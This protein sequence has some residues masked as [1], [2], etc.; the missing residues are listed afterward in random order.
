MQDKID[1]LKFKDKILA[2]IIT[3]TLKEIKPKNTVYED[4]LSSII[5]QQ[6]SAKV[7]HQIEIRFRKLFKNNFP[8]YDAL[9]KTHDEKLKSIGLSKQK[10]AYLKNTALFFKE[11]N[12]HN[13]DFLKLKDEEIIKLLTQIKGVGIWTSQM[14]LIFTLGREDIFSIKDIGLVNGIIKLYKLEK[15]YPKSNTKYSLSSKDF[16]KKILK[17]TEKWKPYRS[18]ASRYIW[19]YKDGDFDWEEAKKI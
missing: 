1:Y 10:I 5:G 9:L 7:A 14:I 13:K 17:I 8:S 6:I 18:I 16:E 11:H 3:H 19:K 4:L 12:L 2:K 15:Y